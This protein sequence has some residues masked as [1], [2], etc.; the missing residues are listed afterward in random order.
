MEKFFTINIYQL[1]AIDS[2][3]SPSPIGLRLLFSLG[4]LSAAIIAF[5]L[6]LM[7]ILSIV[8]WYHFAYM[9]ISIALL[10]FGAAGT[11]LAFC[12]KWLLKHINVLLPFLMISCG[13]VMALVTDI[14]QLHFFRFDS[15]LLFADYSHIGK[16]LFTYLLFFILFLFFSYGNRF[17]IKICELILITYPLNTYQLQPFP[18]TSILVPTT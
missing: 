13:L 3:G 1:F 4:L 7:R 17:G 6:A 16:P 5:Q 15:Y 2:K 14:S 8:Q 12:R 11:V 9:V 18:L 10:G